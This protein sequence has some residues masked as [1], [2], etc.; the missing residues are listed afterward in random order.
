MESL[1]RFLLDL[2]RKNFAMGENFIGGGGFLIR[3]LRNAE[4]EIEA[5]TETGGLGSG[6][7]ALFDGNGFGVAEIVRE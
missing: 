5:G 6:I 1:F 4:I 2:D 7:R 3:T